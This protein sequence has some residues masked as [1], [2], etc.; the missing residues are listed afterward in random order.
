MA[1]DSAHCDSLTDDVGVDGPQI[2]IGQQTRLLKLPLRSRTGYIMSPYAHQWQH[3]LE[4]PPPGPRTESVYYR[5]LRLNLGQLE[6]VKLQRLLEIPCI[7]A[8]PQPR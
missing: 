8:V 5:P 3:L 6:S 2:Q 4:I 1:D 7:F